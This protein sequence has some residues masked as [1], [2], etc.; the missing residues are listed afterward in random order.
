[1]ELEEKHKEKWSWD[2]E[3]V[4]KAQGLFAACRRF[5]RLFAFAVLHNGL[6]TLK[7]LVTK[8][9]KRIQ[10]IYETYQI[11]ND[12]RETKDN[13]DEEFHHWYQ[14]ACE[15]AK[16]VGVMPSEPRLAKCWCR[17]RNKILSKDCESYYRRAIGVPVMDVL[18]VNLHDRMAYKKH[19]ELFTLLPS[20]CLSSKCDI[21][22]TTTSL[23]NAFG[24]D[25]S[26]ITT[27]VFPSEMKLWVKFCK[28]ETEKTSK[29]SKES[30]DS[31]IYMLKYAD[32]D[33]FPNILIL[34][35]I[36]CISPNGSNEAKRKAPG[37]RRLKTRYRATIG[38]KRESDL[39]FLQLQRI[40]KGRF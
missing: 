34:L 17:Y 30:E 16:S 28:T 23:Q 5:D 21:N 38:D 19:T 40:K 2:K 15:T 6:E 18:I 11:I 14:M 12:L 35:A 1:M 32:R 10:D 39:N 3:T 33:C 24:D 22:A 4:S 9:Q 29:E 27:S 36:G 13:M 26:T 7:P 20:V 25:L 8:L 31:F 37:V